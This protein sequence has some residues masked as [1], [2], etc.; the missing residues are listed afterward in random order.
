M[1]FRRVLRQPAAVLVFALGPSVAIAQAPKFEGVVT[2][3][4]RNNGMANEAQYSVKDGQVRMDVQ[5]GGMQVYMLMAPADGK[6]VIVMPMQRM[7]MDQSVDAMMAAAG[8]KAKDTKKPDLKKTGKKETIAGLEC[9]HVTVTDDN[10]Q[11]ADACVTK[12]LGNFV[13]P[14]GPAG[15]GGQPGWQNALG[16]G[17]FPLK[18]SINN[19]VAFEVVRVEKKSL[20]NSIFLLPDGFQKMQMPSMGRPPAR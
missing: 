4:I 9:E 2:M 18:V 13:L 17:Y 15:R 16:E 10:G 14:S 20:D 5:T 12:D 1:R 6:V 19:E 7:Y 8:N 3:V 11:A